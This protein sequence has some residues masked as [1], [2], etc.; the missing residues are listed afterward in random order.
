M[1][2]FFLCCVVTPHPHQHRPPIASLTRPQT[3]THTKTNKSPF[4][5]VLDL[6]TKE[7]RRLWQSSPPFLESVGSIMNDAVALDGSADADSP[8][9]PITL[10]GLSLLLSREAARDPPQT[11]VITFGADGAPRGEPRRVTD[12]PHP[13]PQLRDIQKEVLRYTRQPDGVDLTVRVCVVFVFVFV[14][15]CVCVCVW[16]GEGGGGFKCM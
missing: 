3:K 6:D 10:D 12:Y 9:A 14:C 13:Y 1:W 7:T 11:Y 8:D 16:F 4:L 15:L 2:L 5:D